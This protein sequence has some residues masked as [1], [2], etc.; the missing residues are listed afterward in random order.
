STLLIRRLLENQ[1]YKNYF[2]NRFADLLNTTFKENR[3]VSIIEKFENIYGPEIEENGRR[4]NGF[5]ALPSA[6]Q[7]DVNRMKTFALNRPTFQREHILEKF[8]LQK[9]IDVAL[10]VSDDE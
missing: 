2:I 4:W 6:W 7:G 5:S 1:K 9:T 8:N 3:V 10:N